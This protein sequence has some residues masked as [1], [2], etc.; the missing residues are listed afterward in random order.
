MNDTH[1]HTSCQT[2]T[3]YMKD[4]DFFNMMASTWDEHNTSSTPERISLILKRAGVETGMDVLDV[5]TGTGVL[6][7]ALAE[8][9]GSSGSL[10]AVDVA[11]NMLAE[12][13]RKFA[14]LT[15]A[16][17]FMLT[18]V[19]EQPLPGRYDRIMLYCV[20]PHI[21]F[22]ERTLSRLIRENLKP[23]GKIVIAH[24]VGREFINDVHH[25]RP[26]RS[27][28]LPAASELC[29]RLAA[30]GIAAETIEDSADLYLVVVRQQ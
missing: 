26:I 4:K 12:A 19:E 1:S 21:H 25:R 28:G 17:R 16:P 10:T 18:D 23:G 9:V 3:D 29:A 5:G 30:A 14:A 20:F 6:L 11:E 22:P 24:P 13:R 2:G 7:P 15:P 8:A 27:E